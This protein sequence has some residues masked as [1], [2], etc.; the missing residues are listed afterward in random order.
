MSDP[1][2]NPWII[3]LLDSFEKFKVLVVCSIVVLTIVTV[4]YTILSVTSTDKFKQIRNKL[5]IVL[6]IVCLLNIFLPSKNTIIAMYALKFVTVDNLKKVYHVGNKVSTDF[7]QFT[8]DFVRDIV[9]AIQHSKQE[10]SNDGSK[11]A[12]KESGQ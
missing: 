10:D 4:I 1:I 12:K 8:I 5:I 3:Y 9:Y 11:K 6:S 2:I 7:R